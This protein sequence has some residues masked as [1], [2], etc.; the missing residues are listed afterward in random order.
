MRRRI[1][2]LAPLIAIVVLAACSG[3]DGDH[4][5]LWFAD[6]SDTHDVAA[7]LARERAALLADLDDISA[8]IEAAPFPVWRRDAAS[9][10]THVNTAYV[11]AVDANGAPD[12]IAKGLELTGKA[13]GIRADGL[14]H[15]RDESAI[16]GG[17]R[18]T[19]RVHDVPLPGSTAVAGFAIDVTERDQLQNELDRHLEAQRETLDMLS[20]PVAIFGPDRRLTFHNGAF[21]RLFALDPAWLAEHPLHGDVLGQLRVGVARGV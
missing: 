13:T 21:N 20:T 1:A 5:V 19:L 6:V 8:L 3:S 14:H 15:E 7:R 18:R 17:K 12:V 4:V 11:K 16:I 10:L 2:P 9:R